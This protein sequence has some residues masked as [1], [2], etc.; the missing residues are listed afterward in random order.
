M[1]PATIVAAAAAAAAAKRS[2]AIP[3]RANGHSDSIISGHQAVPADIIG[4]CGTRIGAKGLSPDTAQSHTRGG[5]L[6]PVLQGLLPTLFPATWNQAL[7][8]PCF[9]SPWFICVDMHLFSLPLSR[10]RPLCL[11]R[12]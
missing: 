2:R 10:P 11:G 7:I 9:A 3:L 12:S 1:P 4:S 5:E 8:C 6:L